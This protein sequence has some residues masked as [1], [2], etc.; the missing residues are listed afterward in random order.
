MLT[1]CENLEEGQPRSML[2]KKKDM[3]ACA[4]WI[5]RAGLYTSEVVGRETIYMGY[6]QQELYSM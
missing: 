6:I 3:D 2:C 5:K 4:P 1:I